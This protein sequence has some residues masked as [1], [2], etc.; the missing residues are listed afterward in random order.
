MKKLVMA[1]VAGYAGLSVSV[2]AATPLTLTTTTIDNGWEKTRMHCDQFGRCW[3][4]RSARNPLLDSYRYA[5]LPAGA[6]APAG[7]IR[8]GSSTW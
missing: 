2:G 3:K 5:P 1:L 8:I 4:E 6:L 7:S